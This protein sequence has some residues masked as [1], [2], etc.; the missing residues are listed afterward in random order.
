M[1]RRER[2]A[3]A[4]NLRMTIEDP[5]FDHDLADVDAS[6][7]RGDAGGGRLQLAAFELRLSGYVRGEER[8]VFPAVEGVSSDL[9]A[10]ISR[11]RREH[12]SLRRLVAQ[13]REALDRSDLRGGLA[14]LEDLRSLL[15]L[16]VAKEDWVLSA[17]GGSGAVRSGQKA[18]G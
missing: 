1:S 13:L 4:S 11:M 3:V 15:L 14:V 16:H 5:C 6:L 8:V 12:D 17:A 2:T 9:R 7:R 10:P 18:H